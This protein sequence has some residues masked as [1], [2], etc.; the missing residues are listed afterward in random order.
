MK[1]LP[2]FRHFLVIFSTGWYFA[3]H[4]WQQSGQ[5]WTFSGR[6]KVFPQILHVLVIIPQSCIFGCLSFPANSFFNHSNIDLPFSSGILFQNSWQWPLFQYL[7]ILI[8][9]WKR[10]TADNDFLR[11]PGIHCACQ[12]HL[13]YRQCRGLRYIHDHSQRR[14]QNRRYRTRIR[15]RYPGADTC[16]IFFNAAQE[17]FHQIQDLSS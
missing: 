15:A 11:L 16:C 17:D 14:L 3:L 7:L 5:C 8:W 6:V 9:T 4:S 10:F 13:C 1:V 2:H 12:L